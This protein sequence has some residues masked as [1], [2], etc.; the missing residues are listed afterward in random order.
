MMIKSALV[1]SC[2]SLALGF[3]AVK[4]FPTL[5]G[6]TPNLEKVELPKDCMGKKTLIGVASGKQA[7]GDLEA[8]FEPIYLR[9]IKGHGLF[10]QTYDINMYFV[11]MFVGANKA[12]Y[13][14]AM[15]KIS[16]SSTPEVLQH[17]VFCKTKAKELEAMLGIKDR[18]KPYFFVLDEQGEIIHQTDG[19]FSDEK[20]EA[21]E[22]Y[23]ME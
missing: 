11:P 5:K 2:L 15:R 22:A 18:N 14:P 19:A 13:E 20:L 17:L 8:W 21:I 6:Q 12:A 16:K 7:Q 4:S 1:V 23:F 10:A 3:A 9:F